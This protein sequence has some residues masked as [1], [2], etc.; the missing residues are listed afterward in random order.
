MP[1]ISGPNSRATRPSWARSDSS[2]SPAPGYWTF[3]ATLRPSFHTARCT[4]PIDAAAA[5]VSSNSANSDRQS[6]PSRSASTLCTVRAGIGG[7]ASWS[8]VSAAR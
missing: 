1:G 7:A 4:W 6:S 2:A 8:L 5:G 3:T